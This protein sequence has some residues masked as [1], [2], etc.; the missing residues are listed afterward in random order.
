LQVVPS[1]LNVSGFNGTP[2]NQF[3]LGGGIGIRF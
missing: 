1:L 2:Q 3:G